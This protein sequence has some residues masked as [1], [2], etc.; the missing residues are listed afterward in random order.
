MNCLK[1]AKDI[2]GVSDKSPG[3][4]WYGTMTGYQNAPI[5]LNVE[6]I[7]MHIGIFGNTG[8]GKSYDNR[9]TY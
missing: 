3:I 5:P 9:S 7:P 8:S 2:F 6:S 1:R 4:L